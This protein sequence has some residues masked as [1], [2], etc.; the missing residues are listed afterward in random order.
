M[1]KIIFFVFVLF[2][3][4]SF[5]QKEKVKLKQYAIKLFYEQDSLE[6]ENQDAELMLVAFVEFFKSIQE[7]DKEKFMKCLS[8]KTKSEIRGDK[9]E[10]KFLKFKAYD[11]KL[12]G[13]IHVRDIS[14]YERSTFETAQVYVCT[15]RLPEGQRIEKRV[16]FDPLKTREIQN[17]KSFVGIQMVRE[18]DAYRVVI[19]W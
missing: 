13:K 17:K 10:R 3:F 4:V 16:N 9:L 14:K 8:E 5:G 1:K 2:S 11:V 18:D 19:P 12:T 6:I 7:N 15:I